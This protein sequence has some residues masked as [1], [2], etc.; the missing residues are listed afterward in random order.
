M[1]KQPSRLTRYRRLVRQRKADHSLSKY[2]FT[3][4]ST[5]RFDGNHLGSFAHWAGDLYA[6]IMVVYP[7][8][9]CVEKF[10]ADRGR[11]VLTATP[12]DAP[13]RW[14]P[15]AHAF[16]LQLLRANGWDIGLPDA[17]VDGGIFLVDA[18]PFCGLRDAYT[19]AQNYAY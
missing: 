5:T 18:V 7:D 9:R 17:P 8:F 15:S 11:P 4:P 6:D 1:P 3:N 14:K 2:G 12:A 16:L 13:H 19:R 10:V